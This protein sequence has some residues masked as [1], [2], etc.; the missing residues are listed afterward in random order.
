M[1]FWLFVTDTQSNDAREVFEV[2]FTWRTGMKITCFDLGRSFFLHFDPHLR[3][4]TLA[5]FYAHFLRVVTHLYHLSRSWTHALLTR[6]S[7]GNLIGPQAGKAVLLPFLLSFRWNH[8]ISDQNLSFSA[9]FSSY[10][11]HHD[12]VT[13][14]SS[15]DFSWF[16]RI[17]FP[18]DIVTSSSCIT[19]GWCCAGCLLWKRNLHSKLSIHSSSSSFCT[20]GSLR[21]SWVEGGG[22]LTLVIELPKR[23]CIFYLERERERKRYEW[24]LHERFKEKTI[25]MNMLVMK[26]MSGGNQW[27]DRAFFYRGVFK[28]FESGPCSV[29][30]DHDHEMN[31]QN[32]SG[33]KSKLKKFAKLNP[34]W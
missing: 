2:S 23:M 30:R 11:F 14:Q 10:I 6:V 13:V 20:F 34:S 33:T 29:I 28:S 31:R 7:Y 1:Y 24:E 27:E 18:S 22:V 17:N 26:R 4:S 21:D 3:F 15:L 32:K 25:G 19:E 16:R 9:S 8:I 5:W 12:F